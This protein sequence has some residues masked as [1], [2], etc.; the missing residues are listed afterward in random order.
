MDLDAVDPD[1]E[2]LSVE[3]GELALDGPIEPGSAS[4]LDTITNPASLTCTYSS[5]P[6]SFITLEGLQRRGWEVAASG[7]WLIETSGPLTSDQLTAARDV[8]ASAGLT[9]E[10]RDQQTGLQTLRSGATAVGMLLALGILAMTVGLIRS[11][12]AGDLRTLT[13]TGAS[14]TTRRTLTAATAGG[15]ALLGVV[16]GTIGAYAAVAGFG[17]FADLTPVPGAH[18]AARR[19]HP[20]RRRRRRLDPRRPPTSRHCQT[21]HRMKVLTP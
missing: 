12:A 9:I 18:L 20:T 13:A 5:L 14:R 15:L 3:T 17:D 21:T 19:R 4:E 11:E 1:T 7:Q 2:F 10:V 6:R 16:L 8:A